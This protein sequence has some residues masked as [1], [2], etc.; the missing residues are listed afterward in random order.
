MLKFGQE[1][2]LEVLEQMAVNKTAED[3]K[4]QLKKLEQKNT[5]ELKAWQ[6]T[7]EEA[8]AELGAVTKQNTDK[9]ERVAELTSAQHRLER[10]LN[11]T[12]SRM[13]VEVGPSKEKMKAEREQL[14]SLV[15][16]QAREMEALKAEINMLRRKGGHVYTPVVRRGAG[17]Q[18]L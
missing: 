4:E 5:A 3:L 1:V 12:Q 15:K 16:L 17:T 13:V 14:V 10:E 8:A 6:K 18:W 9:L 11:G 2:D 7:I